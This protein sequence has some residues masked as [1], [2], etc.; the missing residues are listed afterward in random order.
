MPIPFDSP[1]SELEPIM[2]DSN[3]PLALP[4]V[5]AAAPSA[6]PTHAAAAETPSPP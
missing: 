2:N 4:P 1:D 6:P 5:D 3:E